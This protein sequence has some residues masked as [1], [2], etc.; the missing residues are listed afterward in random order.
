[1]AKKIDSND[2]TQSIQCMMLI[3][4]WIPFYFSLFRWKTKLSAFSCRCGKRYYLSPKEQTG[5]CL[6]STAFGPP[7]LCNICN[8]YVIGFKSKNICNAHQNDSFVEPVKKILESI[9]MTLLRSRKKRVLP[10][11]SSV[12]VTVLPSCDRLDFYHLYV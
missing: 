2:I 6:H 4:N 5:F 3:E 9:W 12:T 7:A 10:K 8:G 1:M 11:Y